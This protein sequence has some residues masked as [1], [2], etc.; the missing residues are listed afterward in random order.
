[1]DLMSSSTAL[2]GPP[3][4]KSSV[5]NELLKDTPQAP[6]P[7]GGHRCRRVVPPRSGGEWIN[8]QTIRVNGGII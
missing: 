4:L 3:M 1:M 6:W 8:G 2:A 7:S 5:E